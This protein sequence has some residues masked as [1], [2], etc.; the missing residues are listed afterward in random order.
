MKLTHDV[1]EILDVLLPSHVPGSG[2]ARPAAATLVVKEKAIPI[3]QSEEL[4]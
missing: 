4:G 2:F 1:G 3:G